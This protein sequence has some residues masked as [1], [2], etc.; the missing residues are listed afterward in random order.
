M[1][2]LSK[3]NMTR[4]FVISSIW[5]MIGSAICSATLVSQTGVGVRSFSLAN[6]CIASSND[7]SSLFWNPA[8]LAL[9]STPEVSISMD[10]MRLDERSDFFG[11]ADDGK[12]R[13]VRFGNAGCAMNDPFR[14]GGVGVA[15]GYQ[16]PYSFID[17]QKY[18]GEFEDN[19]S[20]FS[21]TKNY[22]AGG[23]LNF[24]SAGGGI[25]IQERL[26]IGGALSLVTGT[27]KVMVDFTR[28]TGGAIIDSVNDYYTSSIRREY[29]GYD[30]RLGVL[31][32]VPKKVQVGIS[33]TMPG[34]LQFT[35]ETREDFPL[36]DSSDF[37]RT[38]GYLESSLS[39]AVGV[40][41]P[42]DFIRLEATAR[43][44]APH[45]G[46]PGNSEA[47]FW[48]AGGGGGVEM[49]IRIIPLLLRAGYG[50]D[51]FDPYVYLFKYR[52]STAQAVDFKARRNRQLITAGAEYSMDKQLSIEATYGYS[53]WELST[54]PDLV[55]KQ[56]LHR[57]A[58]GISAH[59]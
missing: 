2:F 10:A 45:E 43:I 44:R 31:Y 56:R 23:S 35:E 51:E 38:R 42:L 58:I 27:E 7:V 50:Y 16:S 55:E 22:Q 1:F 47:S 41:I 12:R 14:N 25:Q 21:E 29:Y 48:K 9:M 17:Q 49:P 8:G 13:S 11:T 30:L 36:L 59:Y 57:V 15:V 37:F 33:I 53:F 26:S 18:H 5:V 20:L 24:L 28:Y 54:S 46:Q 19:G 39:G 52:H 40:E 3:S 6:N 4:S 32:A 34:I